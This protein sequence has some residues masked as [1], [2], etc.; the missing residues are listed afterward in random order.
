MPQK[1]TFGLETGR[2]VRL[3]TVASQ[4]ESDSEEPLETSDLRKFLEERL[5]APLAIDPGVVD[6]VT[7]VLNRPCRKLLPLAGRPLGELLTDAATGI[8]A[9]TTLR[10]YGKA[11]ALRWEEGPEHAVAMAIY[12]A[13]VAAALVYHG[14]KIASRSLA[15]LD[16]A[17]GLMASTPWMTQPMAMLFSEAQRLCREA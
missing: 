17:L 4:P 9:L 6:S 3:L 14:R 8:R 16:Q 10:D 7:S 12:Y 15:N 13:A 11:L 1:S 2:L 5:S